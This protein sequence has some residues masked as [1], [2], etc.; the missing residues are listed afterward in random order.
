MQQKKPWYSLPQLLCNNFYF[1]FAKRSTAFVKFSM[2]LS[3]SPCLMLS[4]TPCLMCPS[5]TTLPQPCK[6]DFAGNG[7]QL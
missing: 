5:N 3:A 1:I 2:V 4:R 7:L 6:A